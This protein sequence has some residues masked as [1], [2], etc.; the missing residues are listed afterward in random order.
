MSAGGRGLAA[1]KLRFPGPPKPAESDTWR[2][3]AIWG[4]ITHTPPSNKVTFPVPRW[5][6]LEGT[7]AGHCTPHPSVHPFDAPMALFCAALCLGGGVPLVGGNARPSSL[8]A[9]VQGAEVQG[10]RWTCQVVGTQHSPAGSQCRPEPCSASPAGRSPWGPSPHCQPRALN[11]S[12]PGNLRD[13]LGGFFSIKCS[14]L[15]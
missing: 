9:G 2:G 11:V 14:C 13:A 15:I 1:D 5:T 12:L 10:T 3:L 6:E 8:G 4:F 7:Q